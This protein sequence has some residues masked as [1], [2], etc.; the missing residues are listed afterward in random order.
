MLA[1]VL[2]RV[3]TVTGFLSFCLLAWLCVRREWNPIMRAL[4]VFFLVSAL[5]Y[6]SLLVIET[7]VGTP[8]GSPA[9]A[10]WRA[11]GFRGAQSLAAFWL[12]WTLRR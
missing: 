12:V 9:Y 8:L 4:F 3:F 7:V 6:G 2:V 10:R 1:E 11:V 5:I